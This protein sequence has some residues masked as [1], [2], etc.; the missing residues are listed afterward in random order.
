MKRATD[1]AKENQ[2]KVGDAG[3]TPQAVE[4]EPETKEVTRTFQKAN[5][6]DPEPKEVTRKF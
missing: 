4:P 3:T 6:N 5:E 2:E 1:E